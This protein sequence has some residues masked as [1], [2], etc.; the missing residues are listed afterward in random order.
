MAVMLRIVIGYVD[1]LRSTWKKKI[2]AYV[3][4]KILFWRLVAEVQRF[5]LFCTSE[6]VTLKHEMA[7][8]QSFGIVQGR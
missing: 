1:N 3:R 2:A 6:S 8:Q 5:F 7:V 4:Y